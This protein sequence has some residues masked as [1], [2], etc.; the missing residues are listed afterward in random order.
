MSS[1]FSFA[2]GRLDGSLQALQSQL[3][4]LASALAFDEEQLRR[5]LNDAWENSSALGD[6]LRAELPDAVWA[7][8]AALDQLI[9]QLEMAARSRLNERRRARLRDLANELDDGRV[10]HRVEAR[11]AS[12]NRLRL[13]AVAELQQQAA[14]VEAT[15][16]LP[17]P[18]AAE[19]IGWACDLQ[20]EK[21]AAILEILRRDFSAL[22]RFTSEMDPSYWVPGQNAHEGSAAPPQMPARVAKVPSA[23]SEAVASSPAATSSRLEP[24]KL[25]EVVKAKFEKANGSGSYADALALCYEPPTEAA[26]EPQSFARSELVEV[27]HRA[28]LDAEPPFGEPKPE[29]TELKRC[30][31]CGKSFPAELYVCPF[32]QSPL[33]ANARADV[34]TVHVPGKAGG[35]G[36]G[37]AVSREIL[38]GVADEA[39]AESDVASPEERRNGHS[40]VDPAEVEF[41]RLK[42]LLE[43][44]PPP[45]ETEIE[46]AEAEEKIP[47]PRR[48]I[49]EWVGAGALVLLVIVVLIYY[50]YG[51]SRTEPSRTVAAANSVAVPAAPKAPDPAIT[52]TGLLNKQ[53]LEG[54]QDRILISM[55]DCDRGKP[56]TVECWGY[57][58]NLG[59]PVTNISLN[60]VD[61]VDG[62]GNTSTLYGVSPTNF[63]LGHKFNVA[64]GSRTKYT[65]RLPDKDKQANTLTLYVDLATPGNL[66]YTFRDVP[67]RDNPVKE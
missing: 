49:Y 48:R 65:F 7:D 66:E 59:N 37:S 23:K 60:R 51:T 10:K 19:W 46:E 14:V 9:E 61:V 62:K 2:L 63:P 6:L 8:R 44:L 28:A 16:E 56:G 40:P 20:D 32:D 24:E 54:P 42:S 58:S 35:N 47:V 53:P 25:P 30:E 21:D 13:N 50:F 34:L 5:C 52:S 64:A 57:V 1:P 29:T 11:T 43:Q 27:E 15:R 45:A 3:D 4:R 33:R 22:E 18:G 31:E 41:E 12:L 55:E 67:V 38:S 26:S 36:S 17:G 39:T